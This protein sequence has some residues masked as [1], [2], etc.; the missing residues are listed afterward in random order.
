MQTFKNKEN[1]D[2]RE[3]QEIL[4]NTSYHSGKID[5]KY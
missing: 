5:A 2:N 4:I 3:C 1:V